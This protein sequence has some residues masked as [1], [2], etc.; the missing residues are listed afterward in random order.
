MRIRD[1]EVGRGHPTYVVA[2]CGINHNGSFEI[3]CQLID[4]AAKAGVDAVKFQKRTPFL[5]TPRAEWNRPK[6][7]PWGQITYIEYRERIELPIEEHYDLMKYAHELDLG[8]IDSVW[9]RRSLADVEGIGIDAIKIPSALLT[10]LD[11][12]DLASKSVAP[13]ILS[14]G[15]STMQEISTAVTIAQENRLLNQNAIAIL[16]CTSSYPC[17]PKE[18]NLALIPALKEMF[19]WAVIGYSGHEVGLAPTLSAVTLGAK[20]I[21][22]HIT[23]DRSMWGTDQAASVEPGGFARLVKDIRLI[24]QSLG[25]G[26]KRVYESELPNLRKLRGVT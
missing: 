12:I 7:T 11:L 4:A 20:I 21:E 17:D 25:N 19:P 2:E 18:L 5:S 6:D 1:K 3:A 22:R 14:T 26:I 10:N 23:L 16:H 15:M 24:E 13:V 8:F 9:D